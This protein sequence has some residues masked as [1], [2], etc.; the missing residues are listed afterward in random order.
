MRVL[1]TA[2][3]EKQ[4]LAAVRSLGRAGAEVEVLASKPDAPAFRSR[5]CGARHVAPPIQERQTYVDFLVELARRGRYTTILACD[6]DSAE[7]LSEDRERFAPWTALALPP[8]ES[9]R[10][11][12]DKAELVQL[13]T[14]LGV[15]VP[16]TLRP[17]TTAEASAMAAPLGV[18][19]IV[20]GHHGWGAQHVR[21]VHERADVIPAF[22][23]IQALEN[24]LPPML[25]EFIPGNGFGCT[26]IFRHGKQRVLFAHRR[27]AEFDVTS[28]GTPYSCPVAESVHEP[29]LEALT[30]VLFESL[31][32]H[33]IGMTEWRRE[34]GTG[35]FVLMEINPRLVGSTDL[36]VRSGIDLPLLQCLLARDGDIEPE[37]SYVAGVRMRWLLPDWLRDLLARPA[38]LFDADLW[39]AATDW[40][41]GD[42]GPHWMQLR[43][44]AWALRNER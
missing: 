15:P 16:R 26:G 32:W 1:V 13:A 20:K 10:L 7:I 25:Q 30:R 14:R 33:G 5:W 43:R 19:V 2:G 9:F 23:A 29:V 6:D 27:S 42:L 40:H 39:R 34:T 17:A 44:M 18:P 41:W 31:G 8:K 37:S 21:L 4:S 24:G 38:G 22:E 28:G 12:T 36:A 3:A 11:A 35:R